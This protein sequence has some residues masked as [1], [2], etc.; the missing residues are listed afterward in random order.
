[1]NE[2]D[3]ELVIEPLKE[4]TNITHLRKL[5]IYVLKTKASIS[6]YS[7]HE[8]TKI[9]E[10]IQGLSKIGFIRT[11]SLIVSMMKKLVLYGESNFIKIKEI[12]ESSPWKWD[13][14][15]KQLDILE[16]NG[17]VSIKRDKTRNMACELHLSENKSPLEIKRL[18]E[19]FSNNF[20]ND[21]FTVENISKIITLRQ[22]LLLKREKLKE[23]KKQFNKATIGPISKKELSDY[24]EEI[25]KAYIFEAQEDFEEPI[26][27]IIKELVKQPLFLKG[28]SMG[29]RR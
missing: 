29:E 13:Q 21:Q 23:I 27:R 17:Y 11:H 2:I 5:I 8:I 7:D 19:Y 26:T 4:N 24:V 9:Q 28:L 25:S 1:M 10:I 20:K 3:N 15:R 16:K 18:L 6:E 14:L 22:Q 12:E